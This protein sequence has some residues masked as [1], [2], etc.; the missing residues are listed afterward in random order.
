MANISVRDVIGLL[1]GCSLLLAGCD[2]IGGPSG[3]LAADDENAALAIPQ[4][5]QPL[6]LHLPADAYRSSLFAAAMHGV[7]TRPTNGAVYNSINFM[8]CRALSDPQYQLYRYTPSIDNYRFSPDDMTSW[9][10]KENI[11]RYFKYPIH[12]TQ[13]LFPG[14]GNFNLF[15]C[16]VVMDAA[17]QYMPAG[18][19]P[20]TV[21]EGL[22]IPLLQRKF[23]AWTYRNRYDT[24]V[25][26]RGIVKVFAGTFNYTFTSSIP[27]VILYGYG[28]ASVK[29]MLNPDTG[30][31]ENA[32]LTYTDPKIALQ[33]R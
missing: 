17:L 14:Y 27:G 25:P 32:G 22:D 2:K 21:H 12:Y 9:L 33:M 13:V 23:V 1:F 15:I 18:Q 24:D 20:A 8:P 10:F 31:W 28:T 6:M 26:G 19:R 3:A 11:V 5:M 29:V 30:K 4:F 16:P 7:D